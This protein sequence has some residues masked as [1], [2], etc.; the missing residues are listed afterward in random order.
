[1]KAHA[2]RLLRK[3]QLALAAYNQVLDPSTEHNW[4]IT[5]IAEGDSTTQLKIT[6]GLECL[7]D[8][9]Y[10]HVHNVCVHIVQSIE[11]SRFGS[12]VWFEIA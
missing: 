9:H 7:V 4:S 12:L 1:M 5:R 10:T 8:P 2:L 11:S 6:L 3:P